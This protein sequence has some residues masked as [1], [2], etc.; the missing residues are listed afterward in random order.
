MSSTFAQIVK[1]QRVDQKNARG[2][3][4]EARNILELARRVRSNDL[5]VVKRR[6]TL[7]WKLTVLWFRVVK[8]FRRLR[9]V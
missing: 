1:A 8:A 9:G 7:L 2:R 6:R 5:Q 4:Y 3:R